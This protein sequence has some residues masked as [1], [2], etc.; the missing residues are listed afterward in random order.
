MI[1]KNASSAAYVILFVPKV[2]YTRMR[3]DVTKAIYFI[4]KGAVFVPK[5]VP[6]RLLLWWRRKNSGY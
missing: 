5:N 1:L 2:A 4:V 3:R 6:K